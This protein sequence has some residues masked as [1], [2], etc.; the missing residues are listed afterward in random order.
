MPK[1]GFGSIGFG[2]AGLPDADPGGLS[3]A[4]GLWNSW[5]GS[6]EGARRREAAAADGHSGWCI[7]ILEQVLMDPSAPDDL[8]RFPRGGPPVLAI[9]GD[10]KCAPCLTA[11]DRVLL[12]QDVGDL[13]DPAAVDRLERVVSGMRRRLDVEPELVVHD[14][15]PDYHGT[16]FARS[17]GLPTLAVQHHHA[18]ALSCLADNGHD[19]PALALTLDG[20]GHGSD[21]TS[22]GGELLWVHGLEFRR[23][24]H[25]TP[26]PLPGGDRA[27]RE[28]WRMAIAVLCMA[29]EARRREMDEF[30]RV[31]GAT[32]GRPPAVAPELVAAVAALASRPGACPT[33]TS[34]GRWFDAVSSLLGLCHV[35]T[36]EAEAAMALER[37][38][39]AQASGAELP[40][41]V[42]MPADGEGQGLVDL[43]PTFVTLAR[44]RSRGDDV[45]SLA[46]GFH[47]AMADGW[48]EAAVR[49]AGHTGVKH[50]ALTGGV[51]LNRL[52]REALE[53]RLAAAGLRP[54][55][56]RRIPPGDR[57]LAPGQAWAGILAARPT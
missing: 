25:L 11:G 19:G 21:G 44:R 46:W 13:S 8:L 50:V 18:H 10:L 51:M 7:V 48:V 55:N 12:G 53:S 16:R 1:R 38:A 45:S 30:V 31:L 17:L 5:A 2:R 26:L 3:I 56:H 57:G 42:S 24:A 6:R 52:L 37:S 54:L 29:G 34:A 15:H 9:G 49:G 28:P 33:T 35:N 36:H 39:S 47:S 27:A 41:R 20:A 32:T 43:R 4:P 40:V 14:L 22:W 23:L